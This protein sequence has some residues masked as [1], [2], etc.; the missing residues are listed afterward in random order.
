MLAGPAIFSLP[1]KMLS[2][3]KIGRRNSLRK[4]HVPSDVTESAHVGSRL[5]STY[6]LPT[7]HSSSAHELR[8]PLV[9]SQPINGISFVAR[10]RLCAE[11]WLVVKTPLRRFSPLQCSFMYAAPRRELLDGPCASSYGSTSSHTCGTDAR[12]PA[13]GP[14]F[15]RHWNY[16]GYRV[17]RRDMILGLNRYVWMHLQVRVDS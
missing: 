4:T 3:A 16:H 17:E 9:L 14:C 11:R 7:L 5:A 15:G 2:Y 13:S 10:K 6:Q 8:T 12:A 1:I